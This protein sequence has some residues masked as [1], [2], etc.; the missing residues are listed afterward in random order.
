MV[1]KHKRNTFLTGFSFCYRFRWHI[2]EV[3]K[4]AQLERIKRRHSH[5]F[6]DK[7]LEQTEFSQFI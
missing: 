3:F 2:R 7:A 5:S 4:Y 6:S 1:I